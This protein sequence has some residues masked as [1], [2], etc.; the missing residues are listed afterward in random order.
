MKNTWLS[1]TNYL[2]KNRPFVHAVHVSKYIV[3]KHFFPFSFLIFCAKLEENTSCIF[4][5]KE[6]KMCLSQ[7]K[8]TAGWQ[9]K[10]EHIL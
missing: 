9:V 10:L 6:T 5:S 3:S 1:I 8:Y 4:S 2:N 7:D